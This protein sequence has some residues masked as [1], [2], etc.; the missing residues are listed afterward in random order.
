MDYELLHDEPLYDGLKQLD[1]SARNLGKT[2]KRIA[3]FFVAL[4]LYVIL[5]VMLYVIFDATKSISS[6]IFSVIEK[7]LRAFLSNQLLP[8][9]LLFVMAKVWVVIC[10]VALCFATFGV[11]R[12][13][14][15]GRRQTSVAK[16][17]REN[18]HYSPVKQQH[19]YTV[20]ASY[21]LKTQFLA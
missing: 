7:G 17:Q 11:F 20:T 3:K 18:N 14:L 6:E 19:V 4:F 21:R 8:A 1:K 16:K 5:N 9:F 13:L 12:F 15:C 10:S 2:I